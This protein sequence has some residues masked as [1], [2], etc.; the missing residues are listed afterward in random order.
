VWRRQLEKSW[1][2]LER[3]NPEKYNDRFKRLWMF[4]LSGVETT[5]TEDLMN[6]RIAQVELRKLDKSVG[7]DT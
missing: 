5:F 7:L 2:E 6:Y 4:Y 1:A 3:E